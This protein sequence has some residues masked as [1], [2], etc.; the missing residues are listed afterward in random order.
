MR[1]G[2]VTAEDG[3][4]LYLAR[5]VIHLCMKGFG[6]L[7]GGHGLRLPCNSSKEGSLLIVGRGFYRCI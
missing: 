4:D 6:Y 1:L 2:Y 5:F 7:S 3:T